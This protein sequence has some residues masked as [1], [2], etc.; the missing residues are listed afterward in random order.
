MLYLALELVYF[1]RL[2]CKSQFVSF[3]VQR[4]IWENDLVRLFGVLYSFVL[5]FEICRIWDVRV[6]HFFVI[7]VYLVRSKHPRLYVEPR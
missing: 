5:G 2:I 1:G 3:R 6:K 7:S 4:T